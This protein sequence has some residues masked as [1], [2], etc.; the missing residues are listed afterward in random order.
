[1]N[2]CKDCK[3]SRRRTGR[4]TGRPSTNAT[5]DEFGRKRCSE[6][7]KWRKPSEYHK[8]SKLSADG[9]DPRCKLCQS[10]RTIR[11]DEDAVNSGL[12]RMASSHR[13]SA[14]R[15]KRRANLKAN[16]CVD[17]NF[18]RRLWDKQGG[19]C[20]YTGDKMTFTRRQGRVPTN[21]SI[22]RINEGDG[23]VEGNVQLVCYQA[24]VMRAG[25]TDKQ[26]KAVCQKVL[27]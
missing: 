20:P 12:K 2:I 24:N 16:S 9:L 5:R 22:D 18:L 11:D 23:Y 19:V 3:R 25:L 8:G 15:S 7:L 1:M 14:A 6:C 13:S 4:P 27:S 10:G 21:C 26:F 17:F